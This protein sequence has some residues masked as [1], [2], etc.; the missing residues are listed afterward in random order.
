MV[1]RLLLRKIDLA[2]IFVQ[3]LFEMSTHLLCSSYCAPGF[4]A[5]EIELDSAD[6]IE[7]TSVRA[8]PAS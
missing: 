7:L 3:Q 5:K 2:A 1:M 8:R 6:V 4:A